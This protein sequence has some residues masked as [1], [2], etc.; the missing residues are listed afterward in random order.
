MRT[1]TFHFRGKDYLMVMNTRVLMGMEEKGLSLESLTDGGSQITALF[2]M[3]HL[4]VGAGDRYAKLEGLENAGTLSLDEIIDY[5]S[6][7]DYADLMNMVTEIAV[8]DRHVEVEEKNRETIQP[9][10]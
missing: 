10:A 7:D 4:M 3:L 8:G 6:P 2:T 5:T 1:G 9:E